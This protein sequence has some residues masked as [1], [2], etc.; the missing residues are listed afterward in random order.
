MI[1][2]QE[3][4]RAI[5]NVLHRDIS[6]EG[7][8][9][10]NIPICA[11]SNQ[12]LS[13][14]AGPGSGKTTVIVLKVLKLILVDNIE[15]SSILVTTFTRKA[16]SEL[17]SRILGWGDRLRQALLGDERYSRIH[18]ALGELDFN[19]IKTGT[20]DSILEEVLSDN[21]DPGTPPP[22]VIDAFVS[23]ALMLDP[24]LFNEGRFNNRDL[25]SYVLYLCEGDSF[26]LTTPK[27]CKILKDIN[28]RI[29]HDQ[30]SIERFRREH[31]Q[32][33]ARI[34]C[35]AIHDYNRELEER[36]LFDFAGLEAEFLRQL[37]AR[38]L[39]TFLRDI[40]F[41]LIDEYQDTNLL[42]EQI[43]FE[44]AEAA[45]TNGGSITVVGDDDQSLYRFRGATV[46]LFR[47]F[48][49]RIL[50][51]KSIPTQVTYLTRNYRST[52]NIVSFCNNFILLDNIFQEARVQDKPRIAPFRPG[53]F[54]N[55]PVLG[56][57][58]D[59]INILASDISNF[60][61]RIIHGDGYQV[62]DSVGNH[63][64]IRI[65]PISGSAADIAVL[66]SSPQ[67]LN[68][69]NRPRLP[70]L[71][72]DALSELD[73]PI[74][75]FNPRGQNLERIPDIQLLCGLILECIDPNAS[76]QIGIDR[77]PQNVATDFNNWRA[78]AQEYS[79]NL[80]RR[81]KEDLTRFIRAW[82]TRTPLRRA[83][84]ETRQI[85]L[86]DL[87]YKLVTWIPSMQDDIEGLVYLEALTRTVT[88]AA[89]FCSFRASVICDRDNQDLEQA[90]IREAI[91]KIFT[92]IAM[93]A[94]EINEDLLDTLPRDRINIM[95]THQAKG[96]EFPLV[97]VDVG[98]EFKT[99]HHKQAFKRFPISGGE[100]CV[101]E[102]DLRIYSA[103]DLPT[104]SNRDRAFDDLIRHYFVSYSRAQ[105]LLVLVGLNSNLRGGIPNIATGWDRNENWHWQGLNNITFL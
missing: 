52:S 102:E 96:L 37:R 80:A 42:Q 54:T 66:C 47:D 1:D 34:A 67:E 57:F 63:F 16:A 59:N 105:D 98:S 75:V 25:H 22:N 76:V 70:R 71:L 18:T 51:Q 41:I 45:I 72:R 91:R 58:R 99:N 69:K 64:A 43:Y 35:D 82:Q 32:D 62:I 40:K 81:G 60:I 85:A 24:G 21:R 73:P 7:N 27:K 14:V 13:V 55:Y 30:V 92:P 101:M 56:I 36:L 8:R 77:L 23:N 100:T 87:I 88:Q 11:S 28:D 4:V 39:D 38:S 104:R 9:D 31:I 46:D 19:G 12:S 20:L 15:P 83:T 2:N 10:H 44:I 97:I 68:Y 61:H 53:D 103:L 95:S 33:G 74:L 29:H 48:P 78:I 6:L 17:R 94:I 50:N 26:G 3:F 79:E 84:W 90:S 49:R 65:N 89:L 86:I 93:G 5:D